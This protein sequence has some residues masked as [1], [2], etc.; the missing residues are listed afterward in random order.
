M[1]ESTNVFE[2][3]MSISRSMKRSRSR[4]HH[5]KGEH[6]PRPRGGM[7]VIRVLSKEGPMNAKELA[8]KLD[9]RPASLTEALD[10][11]EAK[12]LI[13]RTPDENDKRKTIIA[14]S[15]KAIAH[16]QKRQESRD[17]YQEIVNNTLT[18]QEQAEFVRVGNKL[19]AALNTKSE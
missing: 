3:V 19:A 17:E 6:A 11:L 15:E 1:K 9:I 10:R 8:D 2:T 16:Q 4:R 13:T 5:H 7:R 12:E 14:L 18:E